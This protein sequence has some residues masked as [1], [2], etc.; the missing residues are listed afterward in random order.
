LTGGALVIYLADQFKEINSDTEKRR[1]LWFIYRPIKKEKLW[2][3][4]D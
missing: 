2:S 4:K 1:I 3:S